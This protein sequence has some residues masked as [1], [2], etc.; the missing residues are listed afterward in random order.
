M[1]RLAVTA[2]KIAVSAT[3]L[4]ALFHR[5][6]LAPDGWKIEVWGDTRHLEVETTGGV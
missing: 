6:A 4:W 5:I 3:L 1:K 2:L